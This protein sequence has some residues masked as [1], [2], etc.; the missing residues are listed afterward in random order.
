MRATPTELHQ[1][2]VLAH[3]RHEEE[4]ATSVARAKRL[5]LFRDVAAYLD[6]DPTRLTFTT[7][8]RRTHE[9][10]RNPRLDVVASEHVSEW[11]EDEAEREAARA[12]G[13]DG[14][15]VGSYTIARWAEG[16]R[17]PPSAYVPD[18]FVSL[19][20]QLVCELAEY[21][22]ADEHVRPHLLK[23][24]R[25]AGALEVCDAL[26]D[27]E[28]ARQMQLQSLADTANELAR[29]A[30]WRYEHGPGVSNAEPVAEPSPPTA[31]PVDDE[32]L[33]RLRTERSYVERLV[34]RM[35]HNGTE[36]S[37]R[38]AY[39]ALVSQ[40]PEGEGALAYPS[41]K[42]LRGSLERRKIRVAKLI[43]RGEAAVMP[44]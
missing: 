42:A 37:L 39:Q 9:F 26:A 41:E 10:A 13:F 38:A 32:H 21:P 25:S 4:K 1:A 17:P 19:Y 35:L 27:A 24:R 36:P 5:E 23:M 43:A 22:D 20:R 34:A 33:R 29:A 3:A 11:F 6:Q 30:W 16:G 15:V 7:S 44:E 40:L 12:I 2:Q 31:D 28:R 14:E 8:G 18:A